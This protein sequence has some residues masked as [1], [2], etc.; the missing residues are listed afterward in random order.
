MNDVIKVVIQWDNIDSMSRNKEKN[1]IDLLFATWY[2]LLSCFV[3]LFAPFYSAFKKV[4]E[5]R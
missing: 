2:H 4:F 5:R 1:A 3:C